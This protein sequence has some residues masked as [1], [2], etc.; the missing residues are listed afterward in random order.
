MGWFLGGSGMGSPWGFTCV[1]CW[2]TAPNPKLGPV[3]P[4]S[5]PV[6]RHEGNDGGLCHGEPPKNTSNMAPGLPI[7]HGERP[8]QRIQR[9]LSHHPSCSPGAKK[10][11]VAPN[12]TA[13]GGKAQ[14]LPE[15]AIFSPWLDTAGEKMGRIRANTTPGKGPCLHATP[16]S[17]L[18]FL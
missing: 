13:V 15:N 12:P 17:R 10:M 14:F 4:V 6:P 3:G 11:E 9:L 7:T 18:E 1:W 5:T 8:L 16:S 2:K